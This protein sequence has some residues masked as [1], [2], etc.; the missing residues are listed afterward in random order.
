MMFVMFF[1]LVNWCIERD[2]NPQWISSIDY[3]SM[4]SNRRASDANEEREVFSG[5]HA[6][7]VFG[8]NEPY[9]FGNPFGVDLQ[10][11]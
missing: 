5:V 3:E 1:F 7:G 2:S 6:T 8:C 10:E 9:P 11:L 4:A